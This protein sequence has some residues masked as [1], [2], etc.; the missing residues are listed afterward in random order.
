MP[1]S[2]RVL[3][4]MGQSAYGKLATARWAVAWLIAIGAALRLGLALLPS[5]PRSDAAF[6]HTHAVALAQGLGYV[7]HGQPTSYWPVGYPAFLALLY[8]LLGATPLVGRL[9]NVGL[10]ALE[11]WLTYR[12]VKALFRSEGVARLALLLVVVYPNWTLRGGLLFSEN[13]VIPLIGS[14]TLL[15]W[16]VSPGWRGRTLSA[17]GAGLLLGAAVLVKPQFIVVPTVLALVGGAGQPGLLRRL[18]RLALIVGVA[19]LVVLPWSLRNERVWGRFIPVSTNGGP[20]L[21]VGNHA[22]ATGGYTETPQLVALFEHKDWN[23]ADLDVHAREMATGWIRSHPAQFVSLIPWKIRNLFA[24]DDDIQGHLQASLV[25]APPLV[26]TVLNATF[27]FNWA[28]WLAFFLTFTVAG[29]VVLRR[30]LTHRA[31]PDLAGLAVVAACVL[32]YAVFHGQPRFHGPFVPW[33][34][35]YVAW[36]IA[37]TLRLEPAPDAQSARGARLD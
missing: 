4:T 25:S 1:A 29:L 28:Y 17:L 16:H 19:S 33:M 35:G 8:A 36:L 26:A 7:T 21:F 10:G 23:E 31:A 6:Y 27:W 24:R 32:F 14:M 30:R 37:S 12:I 13:L 20:T 2:L 9:G 34:A 15:Q 22:Q 5:E 18:G 11:L 3:R